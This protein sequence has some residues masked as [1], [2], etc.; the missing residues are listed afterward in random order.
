MIRSMTGFG[1]GRGETPGETISVELRSVN[2]KFCDVKPHLPRDLLSLE[3]ELVRAVKARLSRGAVDVFVRREGRDSARAAVPRVDLPLAAAYAKALRGMTESLGLSGEPSLQD[4]VQ[5][6]GVLTLSEEPPD[7]T[8]A[9][10]ALRLALETALS[11]LEAMRRS[12]GEAL[13]RDLSLRLDTLEKG[14]ALIRALAPQVVEGYRDRLAA[15]V[16]ELARGGPADPQR[17]AQEVAFFAD[18]TDVAEELTRLASHTAQVRALLSSEA[19]AGRKLEFL[20]QEVH[21]EVNTIGSKSQHAG[22]ST[23]VVELKAEL[24]RIREQL[25]NIE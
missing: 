22:I 19:P 25:A 7:L 14:A 24:E 10:A 17:L 1:S 20:V 15:R 8:A 12:E 3:S 4:L 18:R 2:G 13:A 21:R 11:A 9:S 6:E 16:A 5:L 23:Q